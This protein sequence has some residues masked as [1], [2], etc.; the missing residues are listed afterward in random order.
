MSQ[1]LKNKDYTTHIEHTRFVSRSE[2]NL[3]LKHKISNALYDFWKDEI[4]KTNGR[5][6]E[7]RKVENCTDLSCAIVRQKIGDLI[8]E[9][10]INEK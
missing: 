7:C 9:I 1:L 2:Y 5:V 6:C 8:C 3:E 10:G 4:K